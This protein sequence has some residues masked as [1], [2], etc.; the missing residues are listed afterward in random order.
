MTKRYA[1]DL[2]HDVLALVQVDA[3]TAPAES[4]TFELR[5]LVDDVLSGLRLGDVR[6]NFPD[7][8][9]PIVRSNATR[10]RRVIANVLRQAMTLGESFV[11]HVDMAEHDGKPTLMLTTASEFATLDRDER[12]GLF[13]IETSPG[14]RLSITRRLS[15]SLGGELSVAGGALLRRANSDTKCNDTM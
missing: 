14:R 9:L 13:D 6:V 2:I 4:V 3:G 5:S 11:V 15:Q 12:E 8:P 7:A 10:L 1:A